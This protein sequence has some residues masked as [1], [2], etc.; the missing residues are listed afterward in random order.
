MPGL[1]DAD[2][3][4]ADDLHKEAFG[5]TLEIKRGGISLGTVTATPAV[6][7]YEVVQQD[8]SVTQFHAVDWTV[9]TADLPQPLRAGDRLQDTVGGQPVEY[10]VLPIGKLPPVQWLDTANILQL[11][12]T[13]KVAA[14]T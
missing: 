8:G 12:H 3:A 4:A 6:V 7:T 1:F 9:K 10:E 5:T 2:F 14:G 11:V 13:K